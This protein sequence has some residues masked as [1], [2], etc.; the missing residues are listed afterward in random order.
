[1]FG[2]MGSP[3]GLGKRGK[4]ANQKR[5]RCNRTTQR[6]DRCPGQMAQAAALAGRNTF[7]FRFRFRFRGRC[8]EGSGRSALVR[9]CRVMLAMQHRPGDRGLLGMTMGVT[10]MVAVLPGQ[11]MLA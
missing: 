3:L 5:P 7:R 1:M 4:A 11:R 9:C 10:M 2:D 6:Q 8:N